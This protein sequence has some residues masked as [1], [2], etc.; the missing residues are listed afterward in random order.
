MLI[1]SF[2]GVG[3]GLVWG[4]LLILVGSNTTP[5]RRPIRNIIALGLATV[6]FILQLLWLADGKTL[7]FFLAAT[8]FSFLMHLAWRQSLRSG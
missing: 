6:I 7:I 5:G 1:T 8:T 4:W 3:M 2:G